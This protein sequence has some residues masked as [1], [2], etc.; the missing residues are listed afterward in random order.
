MYIL[1]F[2]WTKKSENNIS[3]IT[4]VKIIWGKVYLPH[5]AL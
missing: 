1:E 2:E 5:F 4:L 3:E